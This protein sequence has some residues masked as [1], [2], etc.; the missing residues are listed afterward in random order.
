MLLPD[1]PIL[2]IYYE[3]HSLGVKYQ[4]QV[5][6]SAASC[7]EVRNVFRSPSSAVTRPRGSSRE[8]HSADKERKTIA[9]VDSAGGYLVVRLRVDN[10]PCKQKVGIPLSWSLL[11]SLHYVFISMDLHMPA[12]LLYTG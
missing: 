1:L 6:M 3:E 4:I 12:T 9:D 2:H 5:L 11:T 8:G 10:I 7:V